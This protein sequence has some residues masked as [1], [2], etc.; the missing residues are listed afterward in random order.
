MR[1]ITL[2]DPLDLPHPVVTVD[3]FDGVHVGHA[4]VLEAVRAEAGAKQGTCVAVTFDPHPRQVID[5]VQA[6][7]ILTTLAEKTWRMGMLGVDLLAIVPFTQS[8]RELSP[9]DFVHHFLVER[10]GAQ[11]VILGYDHGFGKDRAGGLETMTALGDRFGF[12]VHSVPPTLVDG[13]PVSS[14]RIRTA[15]TQG[16]LDGATQLIGSGYPFMGQVVKGEGRGKQLGFPTANLVFEDAGKLL[17]Q[18]GVY[19]ARVFLPEPRSAVLNFGHRPTV[20]GTQETF[21]VHILDFEGDLYGQ[22]LKLELCHWL[23]AEQKFENLEALVRQIRSDT[24]TTRH[25]LSQKERTLLRR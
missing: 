15:L 25:L 6:P 17:P 18:P 9:Q 4:A 13:N 14:T 22:T 3:T 21:E 11:S 16:D 2:V 20:G 8:V 19:A 24:E 7:P 10:L 5:G 23:R 12:S 1:A